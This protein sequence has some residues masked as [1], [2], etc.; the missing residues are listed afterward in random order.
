MWGMWH[1]PGTYKA[2]SRREAPGPAQ[3]SAG[4]AFYIWSITRLT[5]DSV[6][7]LR[8]TTDGSQLPSQ[9]LSGGVLGSA[10]LLSYQV[11]LLLRDW[12]GWGLIL[13]VKGLS[14][15]GQKSKGIWARKED[16]RSPAAS[17]AWLQ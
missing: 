8:A 2:P 15:H 6:Q 12:A 14:S 11:L 5:I 7:P 16:C 1:M 10:L 4:L 13:L 17:R 9:E 3:P